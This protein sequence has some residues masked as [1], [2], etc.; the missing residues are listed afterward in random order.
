VGGG[1]GGGGQLGDDEEEVSTPEDVAALDAVAGLLQMQVR[2]LRFRFI[3]LPS[4]SAVTAGRGLTCSIS[5][6]C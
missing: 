1:G 2:S 4:T 5:S 3:A 6:F